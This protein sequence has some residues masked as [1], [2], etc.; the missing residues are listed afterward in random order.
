M[1]NNNGYVDRAAFL[2]ENRRFR[3]ADIAGFGKVRIRSLTWGEMDEAQREKDETLKTSRLVALSVCD[4]DGQPL[5]VNAGDAEQILAM[6]ASVASEL[7]AVV[8]D[9]VLQNEDAE[10]NSET[11]QGDASPAG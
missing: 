2:K 5:F 10:K 8:T 1:T 4:G 7:I 6:D 9:H 11:T 3:D